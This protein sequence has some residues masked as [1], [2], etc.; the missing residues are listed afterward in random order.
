MRARPAPRAVRIASSRYALLPSEQQVRHVRACDQENERDC[1]EH[2]IEKPVQTRLHLDLDEW[3]NAGRT[4]A[5]TGRIRFLHLAG[6]ECE[7]GA[8]LVARDLSAQPSVNCEESAAG[9]I[10]RLD[11]EW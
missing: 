3:K 5:R 1:A 8:G 10:H 11:A 2:E 9:H 6:E 4:V 7:L